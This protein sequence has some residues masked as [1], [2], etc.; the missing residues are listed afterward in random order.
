MEIG[1]L[2][3]DD[4]RHE[5]GDKVDRAANHYRSKYGRSPDLCFAHPKTLGRNPPKKTA[6]VKLCSSGSVLPH[7]FWLGIE[8]RT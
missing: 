6:G 1:M 5:L 3:F 7:H 8:N 2:W 4:G